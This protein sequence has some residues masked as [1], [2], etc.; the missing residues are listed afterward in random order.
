M[1]DAAVTARVV[2]PRDAVVSDVAE[3]LRVP[4]RPCWVLSEPRPVYDES[5]SLTALVTAV[6]ALAAVGTGFSG[7]PVVALLFCGASAVLRLWNQS[8]SVN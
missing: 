4:A 6:L 2:V 1:F 5:A 8:Q 3:R 7:A